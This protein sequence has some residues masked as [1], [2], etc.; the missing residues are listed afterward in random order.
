[1]SV[2]SL[3]EGNHRQRRAFHFC[4]NRTWNTANTLSH[5]HS[6]FPS[7]SQQTLSF[8]PSIILSLY[9][10]STSRIH[11]WM[12]SSSPNLPSYQNCTSSTNL[13][14]DI[15]SLIDHSRHTL[16]NAPNTFTCLYLN[17]TPFLWLR[18]RTF[19]TFFFHRN[20][21]TRASFIISG[22]H[23]SHNFH[24]FLRQYQH[25]RCRNTLL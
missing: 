3:S 9:R 18:L 7:P 14:W 24:L 17:L 4:V 10:R 25:S 21:I 16:R 22:C 6:P 5:L 2:T 20:I 12:P 19:R 11:Q 13:R 1:L 8:P 15:E 23:S